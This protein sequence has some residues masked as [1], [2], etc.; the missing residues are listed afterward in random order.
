M[1]K[2]PEDR[3]SPERCPKTPPSASL[4]SFLHHPPIA[5]VTE[6]SRAGRVGWNSWQFAE[7][8]QRLQGKGKSPWSSH[9]QGKGGRAKVLFRNFRQKD[10]KA[11]TDHQEGCQCSARQKPFL[12]NAQTAATR[13]R[14]D[15]GPVMWNSFA[16]GA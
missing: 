14:M 16:V 12:V 8:R 10:R 3:G 1:T 4:H 5:A 6:S 15:S 7:H 13:A 11:S 9:R 2:L